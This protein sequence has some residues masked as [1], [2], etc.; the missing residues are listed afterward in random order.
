MQPLP[1]PKNGTN[2]LQTPIIPIAQGFAP[3]VRA[4]WLAL[5][6][7]TIKGAD[8]STLIGRTA[9]GL[10]I[11]PLYA[12]DDAA[13][14]A[15]FSPAPRGGAHAW[16]VRAMVRAASPAQANRQALTALAG[17]ASSVLLAIDPTGAHGVAAGSADDVAAALSGVMLDLAPVALDAG[18]LGSACAAWL[19]AAA[20]AS[21]SAPL[22]FHSDPIS[23]FAAA[24]ASPGPIAAHVVASAAATAPLAQTY[25]KASL[26]LASGA[27][28]HEGGGSAALELGFAAAAAVA[29]A[30]ALVGVGMDR[31]EAFARI[32]VG[33]SVDHEPLTS[34]AKLRAA[35]VIWRRITSA[36]EAET[37]ARIETRSS[38]RM[39]T[40]ADPWSNL[41]RLT[42]SG[43]ASAVGGADAVAL[44]CFSDAAGEPDDLALRMARNAQLILMEEAHVGAVI[45][46]AAGA[47]SFETLT[48][49]LAHAAWDAFTAI[50]AAGGVISALTSGLIAD[51]VAAQRAALAATVSDGRRKIVGVTEFKSAEPS[52]K[53]AARQAH[54]AHGPD[55]SQPGADSVC[56]ALKPV[57]LEEMAQ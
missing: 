34:I 9:D 20:K 38:N 17:G 26:F 8:F 37:A 23:A 42:A 2:T 48:A 33:L 39:L 3:A 12:A 4:D 13:Q 22:A 18:F 11:A 25:P 55:I 15:A 57:R 50:E 51:R 36:C 32:V 56:P 52:A 28:V 35:R 14:P 49:D 10:A 6:E 19:G 54:S 29:Y 30:Q 53:I 24:G 47:W 1:T 27:V 21:P 16:D 40:R 44:G 5:V 31:R 43:F 45:D 46:P 41:V 7:R